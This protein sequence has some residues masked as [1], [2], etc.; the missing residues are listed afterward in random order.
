M[1]GCHHWIFRFFEEFPNNFETFS[2]DVL[3]FFTGSFESEKPPGC[4][5]ARH[6]HPGRAGG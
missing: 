5:L 2:P 6:L 3:F 4:W 1:I